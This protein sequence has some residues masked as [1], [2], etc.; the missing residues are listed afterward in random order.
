MKYFILNY[1]ANKTN[2]SKKLIIAYE[3]AEV[4][5]SGGAW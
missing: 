1:A 4:N 2:L 5:L 3:V